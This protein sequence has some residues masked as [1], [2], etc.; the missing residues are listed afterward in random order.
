[1]Q[2]IGRRN[3]E[4]R[5]SELSLE[6][7]DPFRYILNLGLSAE[8]PNTAMSQFHQMACRELT[9]MIIICCDRVLAWNGAINKDK[10]NGDFLRKADGLGLLAGVGKQNSVDLAAD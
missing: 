3:F 4:P 7:V 2:H 5:A 10:R 6:T 9:T 1:M 8:H